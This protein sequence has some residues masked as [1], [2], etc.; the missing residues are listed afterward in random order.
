MAKGKTSTTSQ[1]SD[2]TSTVTLP[3]W[4]TE[5]GQRTFAGAEAQAKADPIQAYNK[6]MVAGVD[7]NQRQASDQAASTAN[8]G[9]QDLN[10][11]R[12]M[13]A[14][15]VAGAPPVVTAGE[16][17]DAEAGKYM[18]PYTQRVQERTLQEMRRQNVMRRAEMGDGAQASGAFGGTRHAVLEAEQAKGENANMMDFLARS[19]ADAFSDAQGQFERDRSARMG[20]ETQNGNF[21]EAGRNRMLAAAGQAG[22]TART[23]SGVNSDNIMNLLRTGGVE[24]DTTNAGMAADRNEFLRMQDAPMER[25]RDLMAILAG[26]PRNVVSTSQSTGSGKTK[27][28]SGWLA[29]A[30]GLGQIGASAF[31]DRRLKRSIQFIERLANGLGVYRYSYVWDLPGTAKRIG[32]MADE[33][34]RIVPRALGPRILGFATVNY[35]VLGELL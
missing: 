16:F 4:M 26:T 25:S 32:V 29:T 12:A 10:M 5:A 9:A 27:E 8:T 35:A 23:A 6:P 13:T 24:Q 3:A 20:A 15:A 18:S 22:E 17:G 1:K 11:S 28:N 14:G 34:A 19:T 30:M 2:S 31:S 7:T 21:A 33:V